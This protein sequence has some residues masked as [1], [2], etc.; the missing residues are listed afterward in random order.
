[1]G[2]DERTGHRAHQFDI[3]AVK[4]ACQYNRPTSL[5]V[6]GVD[7][8]DYPNTGLT[9]FSKLTSRAR[10][11]LDDLELATGVSFGMVGTGF[12]TFDC[13]EHYVPTIHAHEFAN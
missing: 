9:D 13:I 4:L 7:R 5:A 8:I 2:P 6:M 11:F 1:M 3:E 12:G 10:K